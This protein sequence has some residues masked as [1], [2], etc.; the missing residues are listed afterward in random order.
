MHLLVKLSTTLRDHVPDYQPNPGLELSDIPEESTVAQVAAELNIP[1]EEIKIVMINGRQC[2]LEDVLRD[3][4][5][6]A[7]FPAVGGG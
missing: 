5:R 3:G 4:D 7:L 1:A 6:L 2:A